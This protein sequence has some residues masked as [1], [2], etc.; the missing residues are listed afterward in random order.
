MLGGFS[1]L[2]VYLVPLFPFM[3]QQC[4]IVRRVQPSPSRILGGIQGQRPRDRIQSHRILCH[5]SG[6]PGTPPKPLENR[7]QE[8]FVFR[9][10]ARS[11]TSA[12]HEAP[13][14]HVDSSFTELSR[15]AKNVLFAIPD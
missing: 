11:A 10:V 3:V 14:C 4:E 2:V 12:K 13:I 9:A 8:P 15:C 1:V 6:T 7:L 5:V